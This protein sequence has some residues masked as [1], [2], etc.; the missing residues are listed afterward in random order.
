MASLLDEAVKATPASRDRY[1]DFLRGASILVVVVG[2]WL[3]AVLAWDRGVIRSTSAVGQTSGLWL[4]TWVC[5]VMPVFFFVGGYANLIAY[6]SARGRGD[7][8]WDF[9]RSRVRRLLVPS[10]VL[11]A[12]WAAVQLVLHA[13]STGSPTGPRI[14]GFTLLRGVRPPGQTIPFGP[15]WFLAVYL[16]VVCISPLTIALHRRFRWWVPGVMVGGAVAAD[17][18]GFL[19]GHPKLRY[20]N[21]AFVLLLPHQLGHFYGDGTVARWPRRVPLAMMLGGLAGLIALTNPWLWSALASDA[22]RYRWFPGIGHY[23]RSLLGTDLE[24]VSN[25]YPPTLCFLLAGIWLIGLVLVLRPAL[26]RWL[27]RPGP[28]KATIAVNQRIM[29]LFLWHM[30]AYLVGIL[31]LWPLGLGHE[32]EP[33][34]RWWAERPVW[35][36]GPGLLLLGF[37]A[38]FGRFESQGRV[39]RA[40][41]A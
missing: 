37:V 34:L 18:L 22:D 25:A 38:V 29:T 20:A 9:I 28:W 17:L 39:R 23:P 12:L 4:A 3:I 33:T 10:L 1:V 21:V 36:V 15:L 19:G 8:A 13:T 41:A 35:I 16:I 32:R 24:R 11:I 40:R 31:A 5:Q 6:E 7:S 2:H 26:T 27:G 30:T 14:G